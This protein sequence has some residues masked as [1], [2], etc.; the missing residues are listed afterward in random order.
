MR[1]AQVQWSFVTV[2]AVLGCTAKPPARGVVQ[3]RVTLGS[4]PVTG[5]TVLFE[6][7]GTGVAINAALDQDGR[8]EVKSHQG[9]GLLPGT[10]RVAVVPGRIMGPDEAPIFADAAPAP[11]SGPASPIP[12]KYYSLSS[13]GLQIEVKEGANPPFEFALVAK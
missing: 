4:K 7:T 2:I 6:N 8:Y 12:E 3:G 13:S 10:Y 11:A 5:A 9:A 1:R